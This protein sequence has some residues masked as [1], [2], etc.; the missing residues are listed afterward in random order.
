MEGFEDILRSMSPAT[1][2]APLGKNH[3]PERVT[4]D[5]SLDDQT[6]EEMLRRAND[7]FQQAP[8]SQTQ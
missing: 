5:V 3:I 8:V 1:I 7:L 4:D 6:D 2:P